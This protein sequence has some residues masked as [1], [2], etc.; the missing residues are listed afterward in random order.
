MRIFEQL[1][2]V[3]ENVMML[4]EFLVAQNV[5]MEHDP[6]NIYELL[7]DRLEL[8]IHSTT[9][10]D[11]SDHDHTHKNV[12]MYLQRDQEVNVS[13][14]LLTTITRHIEENVMMFQGRTIKFAHNPEP[15]SGL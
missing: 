12:M 11:E 7:D 2:E 14:H 9:N 3:L 5:I 4:V 6:S 13:D 10:I 1:L 15:V 8:K